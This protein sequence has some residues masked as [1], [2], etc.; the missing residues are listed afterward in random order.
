MLTQSC[1]FVLRVQTAIG[2]E[3]AFEYIETT[4]PREDD[5]HAAVRFVAECCLPQ[6]AGTVTE[7]AHDSI[8]N[9]PREEV[10][11]AQPRIF[12]D[13]WNQFAKRSISLLIFST[14][15]RVP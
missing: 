14:D 10:A 8:I 4:Q 5:D 13:Y 2:V 11:G 1:D 9:P 6:L 3:S 7:T 12:L 15:R